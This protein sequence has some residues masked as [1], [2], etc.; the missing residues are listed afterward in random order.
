MK[1]KTFITVLSFLLALTIFFQVMPEN[2]VRAEEI[3]EVENVIT[4]TTEQKEAEILYE[5]EERRESTV[6]HFQMSDGSVMAAVYSDVVHKEDEN[7]KLVDIDNTLEENGDAYQTVDGIFNVSFAKK[8]KSNKMVEINYKGYEISFGVEKIK[9][10][11]AKI[12]N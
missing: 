8:P 11:E 4:E 5:I 6:K 10:K 2:I 12:K 7:G 1:K 9:N 3:S